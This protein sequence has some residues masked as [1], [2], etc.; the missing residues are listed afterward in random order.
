MNFAEFCKRVI[1]Q[2]KS[3]NLELIIQTCR[4]KFDYYVENNIIIPQNNEGNFYVPDFTVIETANAIDSPKG[5]QP[6]AVHY[7]Q[8]GPGPIPC[9]PLRVSST[10]QALEHAKSCYAELG[11]DAKNVH[12]GY[13]KVFSDGS[14]DQHYYS[15]NE[16]EF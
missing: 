2:V 14:V 5:T 16:L 10:E 9:G 15:I 6:I 13:L 11:T 8:V 3:S 7:L 12:F 1:H 4:T